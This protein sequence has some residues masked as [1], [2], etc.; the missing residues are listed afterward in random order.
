MLTGFT[1]PLLVFNFAILTNFAT[2]FTYVNQ[3]EWKV[4]KMQPFDIVM[5][6]FFASALVLEDD[7]P[8]SLSLLVFL[9]DVN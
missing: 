8:D 2:F 9:F 3:Y 6:V 5:L 7:L 4:I 1:S